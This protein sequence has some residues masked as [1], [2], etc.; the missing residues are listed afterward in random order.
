MAAPAAAA[1]VLAVSGL[2]ARGDD[3]WRDGWCQ[4]G[5]GL[6]VVLDWANAPDPEPLVPGNQDDSSI[7]RCVPLSGEGNTLPKTG[8]N[9]LESVVKSAGLPYEMNDGIVFSINGIVPPENQTYWHSRVGRI[10]AWGDD[11]D[12]TMDPPFTDGFWAFTYFDTS[13]GEPAPKPRPVPEFAEGT[14]VPPEPTETATPTPTASPTPKPSATRTASPTKMATPT[15][16]ATPRPSPSRTSRPPTATPTRTPTPIRTPS[17]PTPTPTPSRTTSPTPT[18]TTSAAQVETVAP[19]PPAAPSPTPTIWG[20]EN[21]AR[22]PGDAA[23][24]AVHPWSPLLTV[25]GLA[26]AVGALISASYAGLRTPR[27]VVVDDE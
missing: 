9:E 19:I 16:T 2:P 3:T 8:G 26:A 22:T 27:P 15:K 17:R 24:A 11:H 14:Y 6:T 25:A 13:G 20:Q 21:A 10:G 23:G 12:W 18:P 1:V 7:V 5:E 4:E